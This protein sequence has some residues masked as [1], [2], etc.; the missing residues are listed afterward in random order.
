MAR[1]L[2]LVR[3]GNRWTYRRRVPEDLRASFGKCEIKESLHTEIYAE[4]KVRRNEA[5]L[6]WDRVFAQR[7]RQISFEQIRSDIIH[8]VAEASKNHT[9]SLLKPTS[10]E[11]REA[12]NEGRKA[13]LGETLADIRRYRDEPD[14]EIAQNELARFK[15]TIFH[16]LAIRSDDMPVAEF[17]PPDIT[18]HLPAD[19]Q[20]QVNELLRQAALELALRD[21]HVLRHGYPSRGHNPVFVATAITLQRAADQFL[22]DYFTRR[23]TQKRQQS[24]RSEANTILF[25]LG[26]GILV[27]EISRSACRQ[28]RDTINQFPSNIT[29]HFPNYRDM[30]LEEI[31]SQTEQRSLPRMKKATQAKYVTMLKSILDFAVKDGYISTNPAQD[32]MPLGEKV[33]ARKAREAF[34]TEDLAKIFSCG[35]FVSRADVEG[36]RFWA[37]L[38]ALFSGMRLNEICQLD[39]SDIKRSASGVWYID[40]NADDASKSVKNDRSA[41]CIPV[42]SELIKLG[43]LD[44]FEQ[45][46]KRRASGKLFEGVKRTEVRNYG[47][48]FSKWFNR[49]FL[50]AAKVKSAKNGFHSFRHTFKDA[51]T[52]ARIYQDIIDALG[53]WNTIRSG[54]SGLYGNGPGLDDLAMEI[55][56]VSYP[57]LDLSHLHAEI[58]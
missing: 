44:F 16:S 55:E 39:L 25:L 32:L 1:E 19:Q 57:G 8:H 26:P 51:L 38:I 40:V 58:R 34:G 52:R 2:G 45:Q 28:F 6:K 47:A 48:S 9:E 54:S 56:K 29:K 13:A 24:L 41:R 50:R 14:G 3:R 37:P 27:S 31:I 33:P 21:A 18:S 15:Q 23:L 30:R 7:R 49:T 20:D 42:H 35:H 5:A 43:F 53:G 10:T 22:D 46:R 4:A 17:A 12:A 36:E 11:G